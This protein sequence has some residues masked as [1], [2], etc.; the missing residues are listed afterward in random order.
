MPM[1]WIA[2]VGTGPRYS[3]LTVQE[4]R[5]MMTMWIISRAPLIW[6][7]DP[8]RSN[9]STLELLSDQAALEVQETTC[10]NHL[11]AS[12]STNES[13]VW[14]AQS[15]K[16]ADARI[17]AM[18]NLGDSATVVKA[19]WSALGLKG[20][21]AESRALWRDASPI[22]SSTLALESTLQ[23]HDAVLVEVFATGANTRVAHGR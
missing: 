22:S 18:F 11:L 7:G 23:P 16:R 19:P 8:T 1:G 20:P 14:A 6:G 4:Q 13:V 2:H 21:P 3:T 10:R 5:A 9:A 17:V 12:V 15:S